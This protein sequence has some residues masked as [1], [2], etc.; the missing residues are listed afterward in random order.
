MESRPVN[1]KIRPLVAAALA[2]LALPAA[3]ETSITV[4]SSAQ[5]GTLSTQAFRSG[6]EGAAVPGYALV[7]EDR[8]FD[9]KAGGADDLI[10]RG[11]P[12]VRPDLSDRFAGGRGLSGVTQQGGS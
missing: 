4:Y 6:G 12:A 7:R 10:C 11:I 3:A 2:A 1:P 9:L 5:P 8:Q